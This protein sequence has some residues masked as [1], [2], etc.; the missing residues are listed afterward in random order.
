MEYTMLSLKLHQGAY[1]YRKT[2]EI[3]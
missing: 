2:T 3:T 1:G